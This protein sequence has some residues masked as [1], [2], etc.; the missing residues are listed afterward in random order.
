MPV[1]P[2]SASDPSRPIARVRVWDL[3]TRL[4]HW[5]LVASVVALVVS[6]QIG[7]NAIDWHA[8]LGVA[9]AALLLFR[10]V[11]GLV[12][13]RWSRF[14][15][16]IYSPLTTLRYLR[17]QSTPHAEVGHNPLGALSVFALLA[18]LLVQVGS[19]L[20][21]DDEIAFVGPLNAWAPAEWVS[22]ASNWHRESGKLLLIGLVVL[23]VAAIAFHAHVKRH[24]LVKPMFTGDKALPVGTP[25]SRD[26][27]VTRGLALLLLAACAVAGVWLWQLGYANAM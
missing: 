4:F 15:S 27:I 10:L 3:P 22:W 9:V 12:G 13:G 20:I 7:G 17:G 26:D 1:S 25:A 2:A 19:G 6:G 5:A 16:F 14:T 21:I 11:W 23:H 8:K 24:N 18:V